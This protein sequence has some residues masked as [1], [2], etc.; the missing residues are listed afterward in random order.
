MDDSSIYLTWLFIG[1]KSFWCMKKIGQNTSHWSALSNCHS[2]LDFNSSILGG[3]FTWTSTDKCKSAHMNQLYSLE[4]KLRT[5]PSQGISSIY[6]YMQ[7]AE[8]STACC[9][10]LDRLFIHFPKEYPMY[11]DSRKQQSVLFWIGIF[12]LKISHK[13][14]GLF[15]VDTWYIST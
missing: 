8:M 7:T 3:R 14:R 4:F 15:I 13:N 9:L 6:I 5:Q 1:E 12:Y 11:T 10:G 2:I